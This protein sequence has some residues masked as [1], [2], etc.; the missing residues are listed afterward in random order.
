M[1]NRLSN[2]INRNRLAAK[3]SQV[4]CSSGNPKSTRWGISRIE[5][6]LDWESL[7]L[8]KPQIVPFLKEFFFKCHYQKALLAGQLYEQ[9]GPFCQGPFLRSCLKCCVNFVALFQYIAVALAVCCPGIR[10][11]H[12]QLDDKLFGQ[13]TSEGVNN[14]EKNKKKITPIITKQ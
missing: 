14:K 10:G 1:I 4:L 2:L 7:R 12:R 8:R 13:Q 11:Q 6:I 9:V 5:K 3:I